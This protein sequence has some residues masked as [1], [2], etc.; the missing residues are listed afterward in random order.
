MSR[1]GVAAPCGFILTIFAA[2][3][4]YREQLELVA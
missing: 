4:E 1:L 2:N 3:W